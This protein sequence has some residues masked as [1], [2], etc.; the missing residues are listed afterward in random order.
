MSIDS[1][2]PA[3]PVIA[4]TMSVSPV[5]IQGTLSLFLLGI[6]LGQAFWGPLSDR[7]GRGVPLLAGLTIYC[8]SAL[9]CGL[10]PSA[11]WLSLWR[12]VQAIGASSGLVLS[13]A[14]IADIWPEDRTAR[15]Y[16][17]M[18]QILGVTALASPLVGAALLEIGSWRTIFATLLAVGLISL[19]WSAC[20]IRESL[21]RSDRCQSGAW[22]SGYVRVLRS[23]AFLLATI[24]SSLAT[25]TMFAT[26]SGSSFLFITH[27]GW[28]TREFSLLYAGSALFFIFICEVN[29]RQLQRRSA[30]SLL[31]LALVI[32][33]FGAGAL[34]ALLWATGNFQAWGF[35]LGWIVLMGNLGILLGNS[36][37]IAMQLAPPDDT[38]TASA[39]IG[40]GQFALSAAL[41]PLATLSA[42][43]PASF[44]LTTLVCSVLAW[45]ASVLALRDQ[46]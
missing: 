38:G 19:A 11:G 42:N 3:L 30:T 29:Q 43:L 34:V 23:P 41:A 8:A 33:V 20:S 7:L 1:Y 45:G 44:A 46:Q 13:R 9:G 37:A 16:S 36:V 14:I 2:V 27:F 15:I 35:A 39:V 21:P 6:G 25:A 4:R 31:R 28:T 18:M 22:F 17:L 32:Q 10:A 24:A 26:L 40:I 5:A 12:F